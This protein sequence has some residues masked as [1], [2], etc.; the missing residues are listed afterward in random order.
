MF[1]HA[2]MT[3]DKKTNQANK[4][5]GTNN[6]VILLGLPLLVALVKTSDVSLAAICVGFS[7]KTP[8]S[9]INTVPFPIDSVG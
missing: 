5:S 6:H 9:A 8:P 4:I 2:Y 7:T 3:Y 1:L